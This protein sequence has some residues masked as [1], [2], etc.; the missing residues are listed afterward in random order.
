MGVNVYNERS[1]PM[2]TTQGLKG[3][4][5][6]NGCMDRFAYVERGKDGKWYCT[7]CL[8]IDEPLIYEVDFDA[9]DD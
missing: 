8:G 6:C 2:T 3:N 1:R 4:K 7:D 5:Q 9:S